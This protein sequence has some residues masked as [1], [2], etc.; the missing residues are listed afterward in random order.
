MT[1]SATAGGPQ[2]PVY[3]L[4]DVGVQLYDCE[5]RTPK[6]SDDDDNYPYIAIPD[7]CDG[8]ISLAN[9][10]RIS[11]SDFESWTK[12][13]KP[14]PK[15]IIVTRRGRVGDTAVVPHGLQ[16]AIG[17]NLVILRSDGTRVDQ[18]Y[19]RW[20]LRGPFYQQQ[21]DKYRNVG[22]VF[23]SLNCRHIPLLE[24]PVPDPDEQRR[25][26]DVLD[27]IDGLAL[28]TL[29]LASDLD[30]FICTSFTQARAQRSGWKQAS[31]P[32]VAR[33]VNGRAFTKEANGRARPILRIK[34]LNGGITSATPRSDIEA[35]DEH[36]AWHG[37]LLFS[38]S[39]SLSVYRWN[40]PESLINQH[41]FK[42]IPQ[43]G[44]PI[45][46][47]EMW[48]REHLPEFQAIAREKATTMGH[49]QRRHVDEAIIDIPPAD[50]MAT[51][52]EQLDVADAMRSRAVGEAARLG[53]LLDALQPRLVAGDVRVATDYTAEGLP[54][55]GALE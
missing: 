3:H 7:L 44:Y 4:C 6:P 51:L 30:W 34:E 28:A 27:A 29:R 39:G 35:A 46:F 15:D 25:V 48:L 53:R 36:V 55:D 2:F 10:R 16:C 1:S 26:A 52:C 43:G 23:D 21:V 45:W 8:R 9:A 31:L 5:H 20:A 38:W 47:V 33:F 12:K 18:R 32:D 41:I 24:I 11:R 50:V 40:G 19:L 37:D 13:T 22:A 54:E 49:I 17:Q 14:Q 42:V